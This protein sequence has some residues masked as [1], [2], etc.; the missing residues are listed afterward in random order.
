MPTPPSPS[1][2]PSAGTTAEGVHPAL[3]PFSPAVRD[4]FASVFEAPTPAQVG[5]WA[6]IS[7]GR[8]TLIH[9]PTGSGKTLAA[10]LWCLDRLSGH[11]SPEPTRAA[12][13]TVRVLY[14]SP[15][16]ALTY[17]VERNLRAPLHGITLAAKRLGEPEPRI[18]IASRTG[19]T[20]QEAR[21]ELAR[22]PP[23]I[24]VTTPESLYLILTSSAR[25]MLRGVETVILDEVH[26]LAGS[27]RGA[28]L[29]LSVE[30]LEHLRPATAPPLQ[31]I[32]LSATQRPLE[33]IA[34]FL[35]G[36]GPGREVEIVDAGSRKP[37][38]LRVVVP[39]EDMSR[40]GEMVPPEARPGGPVGGWQD[41][42]TSIWPAVHPRLLELIRQHH[43]TIV[44]TNSRRLA[45]RLA[46]R[47]NELAGEELVLAHHGSIARE[48]RLRIEEDLK[49]GR[50]PAIVA[51]S[52]LELGIDMGAVDLVVLV[53][54]PPSVAAGLQRVGRAGHRVGE[55]SKGIV[56]PKFRG[57]LLEAAVVTSRMHDGAIET[58]T[59]PRN[60]LDVLAQQLVAMAVTDVWTV[61]ELLATVTRAG[62]FETLSREALEAVLGMLAGAYPSDEFAELKARLTW[63]RVTDVVEGRRDARVVAVT[64]GGTIPDRGLFGVFLAGE[65]GAPGRRVGELD[66]EMVYELRA[67]M[68]GDVVVLGA[69]SWRVL[70]ITPDRVIVEPAPG[71]PGKLPFWKGDAVGR[72]IELGRAIGAFI[73]E[74]EAD[75]ARGERGREALER[76][77]ADGDLDDYAARNVV[78]YLDEE[79]EVAGALPTDQRIVVERF[80]DELGDWRVVILSPFGGRVH[81]P[82]TL[83]IEGRLRDRLGIEPQTIWSDDGIAIRLPEG[84]GDQA[85]RL[86]EIE[87]L[88]FPESG[89]IEDL[90]VE[91]VGGSALFAS[92]F[93][94]NAA[95]ALLLPRRRPG[96]R[97][98]LWQQRQRSADL[99]AVASRYGSFPILV[100]TYRECLS[101]VFDLPAL[102]DL[103]AGVERR[104]ISVH[105]VETV[106]PSPFASSLL[107]DYVAA[108]MYEGD[109][110]LAE[111]RAGAL[112]LDRDLLRE[113]LGQEELRELLDPEALADLELAL[114][115]LA[116]D[117]RADSAD[118]LHDLLRRLGDL[119]AAEITARSE[120]ASPVPDWLAQLA[121]SRRAVAVRLGGEERWIAIED[122]ARYRDGVGAAAPRGV[123]EAFLAPASQALE[124]LLARWARTHGPFLGPEPAR[125]W[126]LPSGVV[127]EALARLAAGGTL[128]RGEFRPGG[129]ERE[130]CDPE[131]LRQLR[132]R[133]LARL[134]REVEPVDQEALGR[135]LPAWQGVLPVPVAGVPGRDADIAP[136]LRG[137]AALERVAEVVDQLAGVP[138]PA[139]VLERDVLPARVPGYQPRLLD[140]LGAMGEVAWLGRGSLGRDD[141]RV[142]LYRPG[143]EALL[144][145]A[146][147]D[148]GER[149]IGPRHEAIRAHLAARGAS[150]YR[151]IHGAAGGG[152][153]R[154]V[155]DALWDLVWAGEVT[156]DTFAPLRALRWKRPSGGG[157][158]R[159]PRAGRLTA[160]GP[161]EAV[162]RWSLVEPSAASQTERLHAL[163]LAL[164]DRHGIVVREAVMAE[165]SEG[166]FAAVYPVLRALEEAGRIRRGY[167]VEGL[168]AAQFALSGAIE[169]LRALRAGAPDSG[170]PP[171][172]HLLA[173]ADPANPYG[174]AVAWPRRGDD[175]RRPL[176]R[177]AGASVVL[178]DGVAV[179]YLERGGRSLQTLPAFDDP[180]VTDLAARGLRWLVLGG[181]ERELVISR[182]DGLAVGES[183]YRTAL[184]SA[185]FVPGYRGLALR[186]APG[187]RAGSSDGRLA[188]ADG[189]LDPRLARR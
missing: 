32:G 21:R 159:L 87:G 161:P 178:V 17:D 55:P 103:L 39:V 64:S 101:D 145:A 93:R 176:P 131:V 16:K 68:H 43:S 11:P 121:A 63:D 31:R 73:R 45:E 188:S 5:G 25:D 56:F 57:D 138:I 110:P 42:R 14:V 186:A 51:T 98:P 108:Y 183:P 187:S 49:A 65:A 13:G 152:P 1:V 168:G 154:E 75:L 107:F 136:P 23:D 120:P 144:P 166:G 20:P 34:R 141:G 8:H 22:H 155:L 127:D 50:I 74:A 162:G 135:F 28:H 59:L 99:L 171:H 91:A 139:S 150:F 58:T 3:A 19:D 109:A 125:R 117:R 7:A 179:L 53:E 70:D 119:S 124:G 83:A 37:L 35:G 4:W 123:P 92:R 157:S 151:A 9:A 67:G 77:L 48:Q 114:Q 97:T 153:D 85:S 36:V 181:R 27:K 24:L 18:T 52:S 102:R 72:P 29:A 126:N 158:G 165:G 76:R 6:A 100:E 113:L 96:T 84:E 137:S 128:L 12:P 142:L 47:L 122:V 15:L 140:E 90:V 81:A 116:D 80:R 60:P 180:A 30:R 185:G 130:W 118:H 172:V 112:A 89:A 146:P 78:A 115:C 163:A 164:L 54:S 173:A 10:F 132:R 46:Q 133:S 105:G 160:L 170:D 33:T 111:R 69:S 104:E 66:E 95:R 106:K 167:F 62:P 79:R 169:R 88:L 44:F 82:W 41:I 177:A 184:A 71:V 174:A 149:P 86:T 134:R 61:E 26:A 156:N 148:E 182:I 143:R 189:R 94:E 129:A 175:D 38:E 40:L 147:L 2:A